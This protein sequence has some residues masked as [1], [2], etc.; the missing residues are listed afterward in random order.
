MAGHM[1]DERV[2]I[3]KVPVVRADA[4]R[5]CCCQGQPARRARSL[6]LVKKA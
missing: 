2:T 1:G 6:I 3:K 5:T 4:D